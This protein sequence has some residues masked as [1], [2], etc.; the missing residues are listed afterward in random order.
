MISAAEIKRAELK[1]LK[2][3]SYKK[4]RGLNGGG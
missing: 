1:V 3:F 2:F 4:K